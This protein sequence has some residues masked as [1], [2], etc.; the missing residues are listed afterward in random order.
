MPSSSRTLVFN[1]YEFEVGSSFEDFEFSLFSGVQDWNGKMDFDWFAHENH[2]VKFGA[3]YTWHRFTPY[4]ANATDGSAEFQTDSLNQKYAH[5][6]ALYIQ[7]EF[8]LG[9]RLRVQAGLRGTW[10]QQVGPYNQFVFDDRGGITDTIQYE[11][12]DKVQDYFGLEP[13][14]S[15]R[16]TLD[17]ASSLK[18]GLAYTNQFI[19]LVSSSTSTLPTDLWVPSSALVKPQRGTQVSLGYFRNFFNDDL[20]MSVEGYYKDLRNQI[21]FGSGG[22]LAAYS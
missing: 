2:T 17:E 6:L 7:D 9:P 3:N 5:E 11:R 21:E 4:S 14:L 8:D 12:G 16:Y 18:A 13:R 19:H 15:I 20:E 22:Q 1:D 10:F